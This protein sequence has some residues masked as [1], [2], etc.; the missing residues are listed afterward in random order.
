MKARAKKVSP[1][2]ARCLLDR[3]VPDV[4]PDPED[5]LPSRFKRSASQTKIPVSERPC[6]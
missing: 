5:E 1:R 4:P 3:I 6:P 2:L